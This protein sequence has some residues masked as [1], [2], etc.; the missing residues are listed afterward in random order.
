MSVVRLLVL[1]V[2]RKQGTTYGYNVQRELESWKVETWTRIKPG[3][4]YHALNQLAKECMLRS[5]GAERSPDGPGRIA[6]EL[7]PAGEAA[8]LELVRKALLSFELETLGAGI[9]FMHVLP[10]EEA[11]AQLR[12][13]H[14]ALAENERHLKAL[15]PNFPNLDAPPHTADLLG[16]WSGALG[17]TK[18]WA[19][20]LIARLE[21]GDYTMAG[22]RWPE[23]P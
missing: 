17:A 14:A 16:L 1:G 12:T 5:I 7:L 9:A 22:E 6:Y 18:A 21:A 15:A 4:L 23:D 11:L 13:L 19:K 2:V 3:S 20:K 8:F 10:R